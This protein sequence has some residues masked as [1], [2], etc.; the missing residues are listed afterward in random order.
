MDHIPFCSDDMAHPPIQVAYLCNDRFTYDGLG[1]LD[2][3]SRV[4]IK[5]D[6]LGED[7]F[8]DLAFI[9]SHSFIQAWIWFGLLGEALDS[10]S[11]DEAEL[12]LSINSM[13]IKTAGSE[14]VLC[15]TGLEDVILVM[16]KNAREPLYGQT[17]L[18]RLSSNMRTAAAFI[19]KILA[20]PVSATILKTTHQQGEFHL[21]FQV[22]LACQVL[23][24]TL[25]NAISTLES[26]KP[27]QDND[28]LFTTESSLKLVDSLLYA[29]GWCPRDVQNL[30]ADIC[31]RYHLSFYRR[32]TISADP[33]H[34][35]QQECTCI[36]NE[37]EPIAPAHTHSSCRCPYID[38]CT[39]A[40]D[41][42][43][44]NGNFVLFRFRQDTAKTRTLE[45]KDMRLS[46][47]NTLP[48]IAISHVR[49]AGLGSDLQNHLPFCQLSL[50]QSL[51]DQLAA[52]D[53]GA[54]FFWIDS[55]CI[56]LQKDTRKVAVQ[57]VWDIFASALH[58]LVL[59]P[60]LYLHTFS[61][62]EEA[63]IRIRYSNWKKRL[64]TLR[65]GFVSKNLIFRFANQF[66][67]LRKISAQF[68][69][70]KENNIPK[71]TAIR[72]H[73]D[74]LTELNRQLLGN[75]K[76]SDILKRFEADINIWSMS[77][78]QPKLFGTDSLDKMALYKTLRIGF[79]SAPKFRY[80]VEDHER[81]QIL[82][83]W[84]ALMKTYEP[85]IAQHQED[86]TVEEMECVYFRLK[87]ICT[88]Q[89]EATV[90]PSVLHVGTN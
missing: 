83:I 59:D 11:P 15:S 45:R 33:D 35:G 73:N 64:W 60:P 32:S 53:T 41:Q 78:I 63:L 61:S 2:Y 75:L 22:I 40:I 84:V 55:L 62:P 16:Q 86:K 17:Y 42:S 46:E 76:L 72:G 58:V 70:W 50:I 36:H 69:S 18:N 81:K 79:L 19:Q 37:S 4:G 43:I 89:A 25:W 23:C 38:A 87:Q 56:P 27:K 66:M 12:T 74:Q 48:F 31:F 30:P 44:M 85:I 82:A 24:Q 34:F 39:P 21:I 57:A 28:L 71:F 80:F 88:I 52:S 14:K 90:I 10:S 5:T 26:T 29:S 68:E 47:C 65:E 1:F 67:S 8:H 13:F 51:V 77:V 3:P 49:M 7:R 20:T 54:T 9:D 6:L